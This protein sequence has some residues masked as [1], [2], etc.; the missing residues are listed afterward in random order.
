[1]KTNITSPIKEIE[2]DWEIIKENILSSSP[3][4]SIDK[5]V[6]TILSNNLF[7]CQSN[8]LVQIFAALCGVGLS[9]DLK[10]MTIASC[11]NDELILFVGDELEDGN[12][13]NLSNGCYDS[14]D[15]DELFPTVSREESID[16]LS[17]IDK[18]TIIK[19]LKHYWKIKQVSIKSLWIIR[20]TNKM[21]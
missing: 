13:I 2:S 4:K 3:D 8:T 10:K 12:C 9:T 6:H 15:E 11:E 5:F 19:I 16:A 20:R 18:E 17:N 7:G 1:M 21:S 14:I